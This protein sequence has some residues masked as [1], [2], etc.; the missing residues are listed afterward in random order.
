M[1]V[2]R[3][4]EKFVGIGNYNPVRLEPVVRNPRQLGKRIEPVDIFSRLRH[5]AQRARSRVFIENISTSI[6]RSRV[7]CDNEIDADGPVPVKKLAQSIGVI[8]D[9]DCKHDLVAAHEFLLLQR[10]L[11][12]TAEAPH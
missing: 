9:I 4:A 2:S 12:K 3:D 8:D 11:R 1:K 10:G 5:P 7:E 6:R